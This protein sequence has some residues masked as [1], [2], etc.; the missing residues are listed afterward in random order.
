MAGGQTYELLNELPDGAHVVRAAYRD[1]H[2]TDV[3]S[4]LADAEAELECL[5]EEMGEWRDNMGQ[6]SGLDQTD[7][8]A[9]VEEAADILE[10]L[11][12][13]SVDVPEG[14]SEID[15]YDLPVYDIRLL[16]GRSRYLGR[17]RR[18]TNTAG[19]LRSI[20]DA[21]KAE[22]GEEGDDANDPP[23][24]TIEFVDALES[25]ADELESIDFPTM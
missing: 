3:E 2:R 18:A 20:T 1:L 4:A 7:Q 6:Y 17:G 23:E 25:L 8:Y 10:S 22:W 11:D 16:Q 5:K 9:S 21:I 19:T 15:V 13:D 24:G 14:L 12:L